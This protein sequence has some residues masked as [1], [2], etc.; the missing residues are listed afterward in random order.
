MK[1]KEDM[2]K[3]TENIFPS[4]HAE[5]KNQRIS[6]GANLQVNTIEDENYIPKD[7]KNVASGMEG[8]F[9]QFMVEQMKKTI[10]R[11]SEPGQAEQFYESILTQEQSKSMS[12]KGD[13]LGLKKMILDQIY[14]AHMRSK[15]NYDNYEAQKKAAMINRPK[16]DM[17]SNENEI[18]IY[19]E[20]QGKESL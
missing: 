19:K 11:E 10:N 5:K 2:V 6:L 15:W 7:Y 17:K 20:I 9:A 4:S 3:V 13:G 8:Q 16:I 1:V 14:P 12:D 18:K